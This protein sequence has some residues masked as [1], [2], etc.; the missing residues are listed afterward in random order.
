MGKTRFLFDRAVITQLVRKIRFINSYT[1]IARPVLVS[2]FIL[3]WKKLDFI[4]DLSLLKR[5]SIFFIPFRDKSNFIGN[6]NSWEIQFAV[7]WYP[8]KIFWFLRKDN[9]FCSDK[10]FSTNSWINFGQR[11]FCQLLLFNLIIQ[12][13]SSLSMELLKKLSNAFSC[14]FTQ[15]QFT[16]YPLIFSFKNQITNY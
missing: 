13:S 10:A 8:L 14:L 15:C 1:T 12:R 3:Q 16:Q 5:F 6:F 2:S 9:I 4:L 7:K 11:W